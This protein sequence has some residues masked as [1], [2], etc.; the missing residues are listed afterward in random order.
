MLVCCVDIFLS[1]FFYFVII[2][3]MV[4][5]K[6]IVLALDK[7]FKKFEKKA[8]IKIFKILKLLGEKNVNIEVYLGNSRLMREFNKKFR[9]KDKIANV[10]SFEEPI[11]FPHPESEKTRYLGEIYLNAEICDWQMEKPALDL[12]CP[13]YLLTHGLLHLLGYDHKKKSDRMKMERIE[14][15]LISKLVNFKNIKLKIFTKCTSPL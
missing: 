9:H 4:K 2:S 5:N 8:E 1:L 14:N 7:R 6:I 3:Q 10:L 11:K 13:D 15:W 12:A